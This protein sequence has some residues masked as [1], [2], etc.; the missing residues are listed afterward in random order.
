MIRFRKLR[1]YVDTSVF[2]GVHDDEFTEE[3]KRFFGHVKCGDYIVLL[4]DETLRELDGA[5]ELVK[6]VLQDL[7]PKSAE[8][9][10]IDQEVQQLAS[11]YMSENILGKASEGDALHVAAAT[12]ANADLIL[13]WNFKHIVNYDR[14]RGF[15]G[16][17]LK[18]GY[19]AMSIISP[20]E[21]DPDE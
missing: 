21:L 8:L 9:V 1:V 10:E 16:V 12:V 5:P 4:S 6:K 3:S 19:K 2:G 7:D 20:M 15:N 14:I 11:A 18:Y 13:S 17:N